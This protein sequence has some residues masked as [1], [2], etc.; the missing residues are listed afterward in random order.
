MKKLRRQDITNNMFF[1]LSGREKA[2][3][4]LKGA[5]VVLLIDYCFYHSLAAAIFLFPV[6]CWFYDSEKKGLLQ[7]KKQEARWQFKEMLLLATAGQKAGY[8]AENA[9][10]N[11]YGDMADLYGR[12]SA[13]CGMLREI[14]SGLENRIPSTELWKRIGE[15]S[16]IDEIKEFSEVYAIASLSG[17][18][19]TA[20]M[21]RTAQTI[22]SKAQTQ[23]EIETILSA[24]RLEQKIMNGMPF[25]LV[26]YVKFTSPGYFDGMYHS[27]SGV[28]VMTVCLCIYLGAYLAGVRAASIRV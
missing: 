27:L 15:E 22:S 26:L 28:V 11:S 19:M 7:R 16:G 24:R 10:L 12:E 5:G 9:F 18:N 25:L 4:I 13:V 23:R 2:V 14:K 6:G 1:S 8:S 21:E 20:V 3:L 17:G